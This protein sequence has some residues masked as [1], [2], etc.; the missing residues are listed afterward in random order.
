MKVDDPSIHEC[1]SSYP[2]D[3]NMCHLICQRCSKDVNNKLAFISACHK[4]QL[5]YKKGARVELV[6]K[7]LDHLA[8]ILNVYARGLNFMK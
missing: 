7:E 3:I 6:S 5:R 2:H 4:W 8:A 1:V